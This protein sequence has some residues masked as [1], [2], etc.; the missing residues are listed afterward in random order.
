MG[1]Y[2]S[3]VWDNNSFT[4][5]P[6]I[7]VKV[8]DTLG[9]GDIYRGGFAYGLLQRWNIHECA[10]FANIVAALQCTKRGNSTAIPTKSEILS[11]QKLPVHLSNS[12]SLI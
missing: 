3:G 2:G 10:Q 5:H 8:V 6:S 4:I 11:I 9:A 1:E 12:I 7:P